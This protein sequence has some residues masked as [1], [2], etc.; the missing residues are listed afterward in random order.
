MVLEGRIEYHIGEPIEHRIT[1]DKWDAFCVRR[2]LPR[3]P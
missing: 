3:L 2:G 1:L